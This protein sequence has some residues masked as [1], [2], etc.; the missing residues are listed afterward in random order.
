MMRHWRRHVSVCLTLNAP[1]EEGLTPFTRPD[2][3]MV[4]GGII[5]ANGTKVEVCFPTR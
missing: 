3:I 4:A 1:L 5:L 2:A